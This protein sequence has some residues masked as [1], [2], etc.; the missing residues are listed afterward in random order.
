M[1]TSIVEQRAA[2]QRQLFPAGIPSLWCPL[3]THYDQ[4]GAL[5]TARMQVHLAKL[6][7]HVRG[8]LIPGST[9]DGWEM[10]DAEID[11]VLEIA[12][13]ESSRHKLHLLVGVL[14]TGAGEA[15]EKAASL[16]AR[17]GNDLAKQQVCGF[18]ICPPRGA[19]LSE[20]EIAESLEAVLRLGAPVA[21]YQ[22]P[23]VTQNEMSPALLERLAGTYPN[24]I[25]FKDTSGTDRVTTSGASLGGVFL[26]RG[27]EG[28][29]ALWQRGGGGP[30]D[31]FLLSTANCFAPQLHQIIAGT[32]AGKGGPARMQSERLTNCVEQ[33]F[34]L[35]QSFP[36]GNAFANANKAVDHFMAF[37]PNAARKTGPRLHAGVNLPADL[38]DKVGQTLQLHGFLPAR[39]YLERSKFESWPA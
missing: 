28:H 27:A 10:T 9:G 5:D 34:Q 33:I 25:L 1:T 26:V 3:I 39:G 16:L 36:H 13:Q 22:L 35:V 21:L 23:Q 31:G 2:L 14:K 32:S 20:E 24:F 6:A 8:F 30:Y 4:S 38:L 15:A 37:G 29:Y 7:P 17:W 12:I 18:T 11:R 19:G